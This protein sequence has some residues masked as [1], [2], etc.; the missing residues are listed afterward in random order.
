V[1]LSDPAGGHF[2]HLIETRNRTTTVAE[3]SSKENWPI[4]AQR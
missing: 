4:S 2:T 1:V 3:Y